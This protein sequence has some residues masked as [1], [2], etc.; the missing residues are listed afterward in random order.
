[1]LS[2]NTNLS[3]MTIARYLALNTAAANQA[4]ERLSTGYRINSAA[5]DAAGLSISV[6][7]QDQIGGMTQAAQNAQVGIDVLQTAEGG[8]TESTDILQQMRTLAT[9]AANTGSQTPATLA[10]IQAQMAAFKNQLDG[11]AT[12]TAYDGTQLLDGSYAGRIFQIG[13][14]AGDTTAIDIGS[15]SAQTLGIAGVD[16][17]AAGAAYQASGTSGAGT[18][19]TAA[20]TTS[21]PAVLSVTAQGTD[22]FSGGAATV[23]AF[24]NLTG[25]ISFGGHSFDLSSVDYSGDT[26]AAQALTTLNTAAKNSLGL[27]TDPFASG[28]ATSLTF[29]VQDAVAG[30]TATGGAALSSSAADLSA[31]TPV[32]ANGTGAGAAITAIDAAIAQVSDEQSMLGG[33]QNALQYQVDNLNQSITNTTASESTLRDTDIA[34]ETTKLAQAQVLQQA[35]AALLAQANSW[36]QTLFKFITG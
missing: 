8:L 9:E 1:V 17:T 12:G 20:A 36:P 21:G 10:D 34:L 24:Q 14:D 22:T 11:I 16:V 7:L 28:S 29:S 26:T 3:A 13:A 19:T 6:G 2:I 25:T 18:V 4:T 33:T 35:D 5:D 23:S 15:A 30:Y 27:T 31:A 32:Y